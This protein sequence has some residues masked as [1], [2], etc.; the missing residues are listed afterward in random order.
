MF[1][2]KPMKRSL[3]G[4]SCKRPI[5]VRHSYIWLQKSRG[6]FRRRCHWPGRNCPPRSIPTG[7]LFGP[8]RFLHLVVDRVREGWFGHNCRAGSRDLA[9]L[10]FTL[11]LLLQDRLQL[12][13]LRQLVRTLTPLTFLDMCCAVLFGHVDS[14][15]SA[16]CSSVLTWRAHCPHR[17]PGIP[18][19]AVRW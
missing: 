9:I 16:H 18:S 5:T 17:F 10:P 15:D 8:P 14:T 3:T 12:I 6:K 1:A 2:K 4:D 13:L 7:R 11:H 19:N